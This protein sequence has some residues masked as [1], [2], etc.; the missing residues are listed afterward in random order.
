MSLYRRPAR[1]ESPLRTP[2][3]RRS[4]LPRPRKVQR[5]RRGEPRPRA[6]W[7]QRRC[8]Q[9]SG[10]QTAATCPTLSCRVPT[11]AM[12]DKHLVR[13]PTQNYDHPYRLARA[14]RDAGITSYG[15]SGKGA[16]AVANEPPE[17]QSP[18]RSEFAPRWP[19]KARMRTTTGTCDGH[20]EE[21]TEC[22]EPT[23]FALRTPG[24]RHT[25]RY[26]SPS[27][28]LAHCMDA[29]GHGQAEQRDTA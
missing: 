21:T 3:R 27:P 12:A 15:R 7:P 23:D 8:S 17:V 22:P 1:P 16:Y 4:C 5:P 14:P 26:N 13:R 11:R 9:S 18:G 25:M 10:G 20:C 24:E 28:M 2:C 6:P 29:G 19:L